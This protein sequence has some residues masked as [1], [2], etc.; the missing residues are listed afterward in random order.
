MEVLRLSRRWCFKSRS[1]RFW[2]R[3]VLQCDS[4]VG[5]DGG[6][7][8][9][10][11]VGILP[12]HYTASEPGRPGIET[13]TDFMDSFF[14][15]QWVSQPLEEI[16]AFCGTR[17][18]IIVYRSCRYWPLPILSQVNSFLELH[19]DIFPS[20]VGSSKQ[21]ITTKILYAFPICPV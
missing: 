17:G 18:F 8:V 6:N 2:H 12:Q 11:N 10:L 15:S 3:I 1:S 5:E 21:T 9:L 16:P 19:S 14:R 4:D 13:V 20:S 7:M